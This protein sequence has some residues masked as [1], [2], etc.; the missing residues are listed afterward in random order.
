MDEKIIQFYVLSTGGHIPMKVISGSTG[1]E[2]WLSSDVT[3]RTKTITRVATEVK[4]TIPTGYVGVIHSKSGLVMEGIV[5]VAGVI[6]EDYQ[7]EIRLF[8]HN[9]TKADYKVLKENPIAEM[10]I[11]HTDKL[12]VIYHTRDC[13]PLTVNLQVTRGDK[14]F[15]KATNL[16]QAQLTDDLLDNE[17]RCSGACAHELWQTPVKPGDEE[18]Y[19]I[20][21]TVSVTTSFPDAIPSAP[22]KKRPEIPPK[23][24]MGTIKEGTKVFHF[25]Q[26]TGSTVTVTKAL[27]KDTLNSSTDSDDVPFVNHQG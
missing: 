5:A 7:G 2:F 8:M 9:M 15:G 25:P 19:L 11:Y 3:L 20:K 4:V 24:V 18:H 12:P 16:F 1:H 10:V 17:V 13:T 27:F 22:W 23:P 6:N 26:S 14:G 21:S